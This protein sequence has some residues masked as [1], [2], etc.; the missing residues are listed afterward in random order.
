MG[1]LDIERLRKSMARAVPAFR[2]EHEWHGW[3][4]AGCPLCELDG[5]LDTYEAQAARIA[6]LEAAA[7]LLRDLARACIDPVQVDGFMH[8]LNSEQAGQLREALRY[9]R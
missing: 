1:D 6:E 7:E 5:L 2:E 8:T 3:T 9:G 4:D